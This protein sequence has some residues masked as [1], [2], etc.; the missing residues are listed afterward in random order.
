[1]GQKSV[2]KLSEEIEAEKVKRINFV[3]VIQGK[4]RSQYPSY[5]HRPTAPSHPLSYLLLR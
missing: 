3:W 4:S 1:M 5:A 2:V